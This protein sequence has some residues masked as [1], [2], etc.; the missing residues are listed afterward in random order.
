[1]LPV[2]GAALFH[3][4]EPE[5]Q[6]APQTLSV[7]APPPSESWVQPCYYSCCSRFLN[8][9]DPWASIMG[10]GKSLRQ[11]GGDAIGP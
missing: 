7:L 11:Q 10:P 2:L 8:P 5:P 3:L 4:S 1:M 6:P 9:H